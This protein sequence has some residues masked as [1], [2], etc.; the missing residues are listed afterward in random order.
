VVAEAGNLVVF[1][2]DKEAIPRIDRG[3]YFIAMPCLIIA[4]LKLYL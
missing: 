3:S 2:I 1:H 4:A